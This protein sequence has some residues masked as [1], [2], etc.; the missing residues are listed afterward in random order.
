M[1]TVTIK[2]PD[3]LIERVRELSAAEGL[4]ID[5]FIASAAAEKLS[6][7]LTVEH[8]RRRASAAR[9]EDFHRFLSLSPDV[10]PAENDRL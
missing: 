1:S 5:Q 9:R 2:L 10:P 8:L 3:N 7:F 6:A 4:T